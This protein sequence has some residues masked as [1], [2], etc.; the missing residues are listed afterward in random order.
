[1]RG[2]KTLNSEE[3]KQRINRPVVGCSVIIFGIGLLGIAFCMLA[4]LYA[5]SFGSYRSVEDWVFK[6]GAVSLVM[7]GVGVVGLSLCGIDVNKLRKH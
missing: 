6:A 4:V 7:L 3:P 2:G 5:A 1:M